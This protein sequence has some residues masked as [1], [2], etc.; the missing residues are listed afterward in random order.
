MDWLDTA[1]QLA[2]TAVCTS[3]ACT[4][5]TDMAWMPQYAETRQS[6]FSS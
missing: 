5:V 2:Y 6:I 3:L 4:T 1:Y